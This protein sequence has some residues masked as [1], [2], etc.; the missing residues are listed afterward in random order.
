MKTYY[1]PTIP[2]GY[3]KIRANTKI[4]RGDK[5]NYQKIDKKMNYIYDHWDD[6]ISSVGSI[7]NNDN[8]IKPNKYIV[9]RPVLRNNG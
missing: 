7:Y 3:R 5:F 9:I 1:I 6:C 4:R 8:E 2:I